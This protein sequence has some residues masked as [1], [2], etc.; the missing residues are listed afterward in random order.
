MA[1]QLARVFGTEEDPVNCAF[2]FKVGVCRHGELCSKKHNKPM[3]SR[4]LLLTNMY[5]NTPQGIAIGMEHPWDDD[6]YDMAQQHLEAFYT[7][8]VLVMAD[9]GEIEEVVVVENTVEYQ[10]GNVY[11]KF[12]YEEDA[13][14]ALVGL[15]G[16]FYFGKLINAEYT[17]VT[18]FR[19]ARCRAF[20]ETY[21]TR[22]GA[23]RFLH[24]R[25]IPTAIKRRV[26]REMY[27]EHTEYTKPRKRVKD[28]SPPGR[29]PGKGKG[30]GKGYPPIEDRRAGGPGGFG[31][32]LALESG[33]PP[34]EFR[35][36]PPPSSLASEP[37]SFMQARP[38]GPQ[39]GAALA[40]EKGGPFESTP[41]V[42]PVRGKIA[43]GS[44]YARGGMD[45]GALA[46]RDQPPSL[47]DRRMLEHGA[48]EQ[49]D[50]RRGQQAVAFEAE[51]RRRSFREQEPV[52]FNPD[53]YPEDVPQSAQEPP[54]P[55]RRD[56]FSDAD[57]GGG[58]LDE[59]PGER[60]RRRRDDLDGFEGGLGPEDEPERPRRRRREE[61]DE[62]DQAPED[63]R[64]PRRRNRENPNFGDVAGP[65]PEEEL[66]MASPPEH[67]RERRGGRVVDDG[68]GPVDD[69]AIEP[70]PAHER[71]RE[72]RSD[73]DDDDLAGEE[74]PLDQKRR[75]NLRSR[76]REQGGDY[77]G[78]GARDR[79]GRLDVLD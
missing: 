14:K 22:G 16:R 51:P 25:H 54:L 69:D 36:Q 58:P 49:M 73:R 26:A 24:I 15:T 72:R 46:V 79:N 7:E 60:R 28:P 39:T 67:R 74:V 2:Y 33:P 11:V 38:R 6:M 65:P 76:F 13:A 77:E 17:P 64:R 12:Y 66:P 18:D 68:Y 32:Q 63:G 56:A 5:P 75:V 29:P 8:V 30:G 40:R 61:L 78:G 59:H 71:R 9:Y 43:F 45:G 27:K 23:C 44:G 21:C 31:G 34:P 42:P 48:V 50:R 4:T 35:R 70:P 3:S 19:E 20:H 55:R 52:A 37:P 47:E 1:E 62:H 57:M 53:A 41:L 10:M